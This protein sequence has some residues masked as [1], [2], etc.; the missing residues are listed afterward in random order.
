MATHKILVVEEEEE[1][2]GEGLGEG[3]RRGRMGN[4]GRK[5][6]EFS[7][8]NAEKVPKLQLLHHRTES[9]GQRWGDR[10]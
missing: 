6:S 7:Q 5:R 8:L 1:G 9:E 10:A 2:K 3:R 4:L